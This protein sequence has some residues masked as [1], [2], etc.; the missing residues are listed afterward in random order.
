MLFLNQ[1][2]FSNSFKWLKGSKLVS[3]SAQESLRWLYLWLNTLE[4]YVQEFCSFFCLYKQTQD[5]SYDRLVIRYSSKEL[6]AVSFVLANRNIFF[7]ISHNGNVASIW[8]CHW[9]IYSIWSLRW[10]CDTPVAT[11]NVRLRNYLCFSDIQLL[12]VSISVNSVKHNTCSDREWANTGVIQA[13]ADP[14][15]TF[16]LILPWNGTSSA[17]DLDS[18]PDLSLSLQQTFLSFFYFFPS[19]KPVS[20]LSHLPKLSPPQRLWQTSVWQVTMPASFQHPYYLY[21]RYKTNTYV[22]LRCYDVMTSV[23]VIIVKC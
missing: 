21:H 4:Q 23:T 14:A 9:E 1:L 13:T 11:A 8:K 22:T 6:H 7:L 3:L 12:C 20:C 19:R 17:M 10:C 18:F 2:I 16:V 5:L 15:L